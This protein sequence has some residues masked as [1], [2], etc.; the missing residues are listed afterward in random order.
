[1]YHYL[2]NTGLEADIILQ[3]DDGR[4]AAFEVKLGQAAVDTAAKR[5]LL[6]SQRVEMAE[7]VGLGVIVGTGYGYTRP[8]GVAVI[9]IGSLGP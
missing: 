9:P 7:N 5:L 4:W 1:V 6:L 2:D 8:D 3:L